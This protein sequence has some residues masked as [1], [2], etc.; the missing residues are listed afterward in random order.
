MMLLDHL[1]KG[2]AML[3]MGAGV[4]AAD[5]FQMGISP[6]DQRRM[7]VEGI[8][9]VIRLMRGEVVSMETDWFTLREARVHLPPYSQSGIEMAVACARSPAGA[10]AAG[11]WGIPML[12]IGGSSPESLKFHIGNWQ[13]YE[14]CARQH[15]H[16][17]DRSQ[18]RMGS[19]MHLAPTR[20]QAFE[21]VKFGLVPWARYLKEVTS[22]EFVPPDSPDPAAYVVEHG[23]GIIGTPDDAIRY[24]EQIHQGTGGFGVHLDFAHNWADWENTKRSYELL[25]RYVIPHFRG[26]L[27][28]RRAS[29]DFCIDNRE[30]FAGATTQAVQVANRIAGNKPG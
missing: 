15:G 1:T 14:D 5:A 22:F 27:R 23:V 6:A 2:R 9:A 20:E 26:T 19:L 24:I 16:Q 8:E 25:A 13:V 10:L 11:Q 12:A 18:W 17:P 7:M 21:N 29:Y 3:G 28:S 30:G 4:L